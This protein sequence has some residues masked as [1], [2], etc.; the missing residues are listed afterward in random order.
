M[1]MVRQHFPEMRSKSE[2]DGG[3]P[4]PGE[5]FADTM[6]RCAW[7]FF[8]AHRIMAQHEAGQA[9]VRK[10]LEHYRATGDVL[11]EARAECRRRGIKWLAWLAANVTNVGRARVYHYIAF[12]ELLVTRNLTPDDQWEAWRRI[13]GNVP[14]DDDGDAGTN[15]EGDGETSDES[16]APGTGD[17]GLAASPAAPGSAPAG[18][19]AA[20]QDPEPKRVNAEH[21]RKQGALGPATLL[22][23]E[24]MPELGMDDGDGDVARDEYSEHLSDPSPEL[25]PSPQKEDIRLV[26]GSPGDRRRFRSRVGHLK[27]AH[28]IDNDTDFFVAAVDRWY[29]EEV[30]RD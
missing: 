21:A 7:G 19:T 5:T 29:E 13:S 26:F 28:G 20:G 14:K 3:L 2:Y 30:T 27:H 18:S 1:R 16:D 6:R 11:I 9:A 4:Y 12:A 15:H 23:P 8:L 22:R 17:P 24:M 25:A 10:G